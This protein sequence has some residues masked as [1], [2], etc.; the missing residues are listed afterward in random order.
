MTVQ[1]PQTP[2]ATDQDEGNRRPAPPTP[3]ARIDSHDQAIAAAQALA[4]DWAPK[5]AE[6]DRDRILPWAEIED[7]TASG[8]V[9]ITIP[10]E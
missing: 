9:S 1:Q 8:L 2:A 3:P 5:A 6:R 7:F 10:Q 4:A